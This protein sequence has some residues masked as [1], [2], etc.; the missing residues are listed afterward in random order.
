MVW[1]LVK[2][3]NRLKEDHEDF[4]LSPKQWKKFS[5]T[6]DLRW[7]SVSFCR[8]EAQDVPKIR[9]V[10]AFIITA[11]RQGARAGPAPPHA[12]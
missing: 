1:D 12:G 7:R 2:V 3:V 6:A 8:D 9:G 5:V 11:S 10:Y 4:W